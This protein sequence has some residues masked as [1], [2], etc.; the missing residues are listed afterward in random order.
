MALIGMV[1]PVNPG[2]LLA[3]VYNQLVETGDAGEIA[4]VSIPGIYIKLPEMRPNKKG[5]VI[6]KQVYTPVAAVATI[7]LPE[8]M[9]HEQVAIDITDPDEKA[10]HF[11][12]SYLLISNRFDA[13][14]QAVI[15][16]AKR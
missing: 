2:K 13:P 10:T 3:M 12:G 15:A 11:K 9:D 5:K 8:V 7:R 6:R 16:Y 1:S 14:E 4:S